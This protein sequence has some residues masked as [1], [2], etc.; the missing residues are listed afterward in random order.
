M[1]YRDQLEAKIDKTYAKLEK[2]KRDYEKT[3]KRH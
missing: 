1:D 3:L 2:D